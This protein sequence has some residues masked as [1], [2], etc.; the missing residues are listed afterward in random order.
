MLALLPALV[1]FFEKLTI[2]VR[3]DFGAELVE[4]RLDPALDCVSL[5]DLANLDHALLGLG[6]LA[7]LFLF[8]HR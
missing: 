4:A 5:A 3:S 2:Q 7:V 1:K 8:G 6:Q